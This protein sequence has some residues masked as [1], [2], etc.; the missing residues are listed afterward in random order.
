[1][2]LGLSNITVAEPEV[3]VALMLILDYSCALYVASSRNYY[4]ETV[5]T[6]LLGS[7]SILRKNYIT[8]RSVNMCIR[9]IQ[10]III[11]AGEL[12]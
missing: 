10:L 8:E 3:S 4:G 7:I 11:L 6:L 9:Y 1:M 2:L 12:C 5:L